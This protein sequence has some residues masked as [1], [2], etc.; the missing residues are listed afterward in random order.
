MT[1]TV[2]VSSILPFRFCLGLSAKS[3]RLQGQGQER[4]FLLRLALVLPL[5]LPRVEDNQIQCR[6]LLGSIQSRPLLLPL[7]QQL[8]QRRHRR[9]PHP[10]L[11]S[12]RLPRNYQNR[13]PPLAKVKVSHL[14]LAI[15]L[16]CH[17]S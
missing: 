17:H 3:Q 12:N 7:R 2:N 14:P 10:P 15:V 5:P 16:S 4:L 1:W 11:A 9:P 8:H 6:P 13:P